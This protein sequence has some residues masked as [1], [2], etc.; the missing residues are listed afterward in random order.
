MN[1]KNSPI[2]VI[3]EICVFSKNKVKH[4]KFPNRMRYYP[5]DLIEYNKIVKGDKKQ[6]VTDLSNTHNFNRPSHV[7]EYLREYTNYPC[8]LLEYDHQKDDIGSHPTQK[9]LLLA[10]YII[11]TYTKEGD[12]VL[13]SCMG[14]GTIPLAAKM[15]NRKYIGIELT[16]EWFTKSC[17]RLSNTNNLLFL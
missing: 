1:A 10:K 9:P 16:E 15:L 5:Q 13:D 4:A 12:M 11:S 3:E 17:E 6:S 8:N 14:S 2:K 7:K